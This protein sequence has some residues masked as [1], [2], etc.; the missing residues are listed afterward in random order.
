MPTF[1]CEGLSEEILAGHKRK[2]GML[3]VIRTG[4]TFRRYVAK[5]IRLRMSHFLF[6]MHQSDYINT[7]LMG[8]SE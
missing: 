3:Y 6:Y 1:P 7:P 2:K 4:I 5:V 8:S